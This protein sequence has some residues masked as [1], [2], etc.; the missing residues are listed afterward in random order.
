[1]NILNN[2]HAPIPHPLKKAFNIKLYNEVWFSQPIDTS[3]PKL[4]G[5]DDDDTHQTGVHPNS[6]MA[7]MDQNRCQSAVPLVVS[8]VPFHVTLTN[9]LHLWQTIQ[10]SRDKLFFVSFWPEGKLR[11]R[12]YLV[13]VDLEQT[14]HTSAQH[15]APE[16][17]GVYYVHFF[18]RHP[19]D[20]NETDPLARWWPEWREYSTGHDG[21]IDYGVRVLFPSTRTPNADRF[22]AWA[23]VVKLSNPTVC[24]L[25]PFDFMKPDENYAGQSPSYRQYVPTEL[26]AQLAELC[27]SN[28]ILP[29]RLTISCFPGETRRNVDE[30]RDCFN[31]TC[32]RNAETRYDFVFMNRNKKIQ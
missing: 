3:P 15:G 18:A 10:Q 20:N 4:L 26:W 5:N 19:A 8:D 32:A 21:I 27:V 11:G 17:S 16:I 28:G 25:G 23:D 1:M 22:I 2:V 30:K 31:Q 24:L 29:P 9:P 6:A 12:W 13:R 14:E 7:S